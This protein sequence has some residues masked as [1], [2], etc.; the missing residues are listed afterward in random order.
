MSRNWPLL[1]GRKKKC[2]PD[3]GSSTC[4]GQ[5]FMKAKFTWT[6]GTSGCLGIKSEKVKAKRRVPR[7]ALESKWRKIPSQSFLLQTPVLQQYHFARQVHERPYISYIL[8]ETGGDRG[9]FGWDQA[10]KA[11]CSKKELYCV[12]FMLDHWT[13][14]WC[15]VAFLFLS[16]WSFLE[17]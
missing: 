5:E 13:V 1:V 3:L 12:W 10:G 15:P 6:S 17:E 4:Q 11:L 16:C 7:E 14:S 2:A 9:H 8:E